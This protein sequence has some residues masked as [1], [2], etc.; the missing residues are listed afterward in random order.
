MTRTHKVFCS[1]LSDDFRHEVRRRPTAA[2]LIISE[3]FGLVVW[4][5]AVMVICAVLTLSELLSGGPRASLRSPAVLPWLCPRSASSPRPGSSPVPRAVVLRSRALQPN[6]SRGRAHRAAC[7]PQELR[8]QLQLRGSGS[9]SVWD[10]R[11]PTAAAAA[12]Q[13]E[14]SSSQA[15]NE[16][17]EAGEGGKEGRKGG[18][19]VCCGEPVLMVFCGGCSLAPEGAITNT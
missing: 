1:L 19:G 4:N 5:V 3:L 9:L 10:I 11:T 12:S 8:D 18:R 6:R 16:R 14:E 15:A 7:S 13:L 17:P 2:R